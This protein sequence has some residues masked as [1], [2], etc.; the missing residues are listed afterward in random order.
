MP[1]GHGRKG[2]LMERRT[3]TIWGIVVAIWIGMS[4]GVQAQGVPVEVTKISVIGNDRAE[5][6]LILRLSGLTEGMRMTPE[7]VANAI[8]SLYAL[9]LFS[10]VRV[11]TEE[12]PEGG[13][14]MEI[15]VEELPSLRTLAFEGNRKIKKEELSDEVGFLEGQVVGPKEIRDAE[16]DIL[17]M[18]EEEGYHLA[19]VRGEVSDLDE[20]GGAEISFH[21]EEGQ[22]VRV[23]RIRIFDNDAIESSDLLKEMETKEDRWWR[24]GDFDEDVYREDQ[25]K[26]LARYRREG[27][28]DAEVVRDSLY[29]SASKKDLFIDITIHEGTQYRFG[30]ISWE[31]NDLVS[32]QALSKK[33]EIQ[34][35]EPFNEENLTL[36]RY[37]IETEYQERGYLA[38]RAIPR[39]MPAED[40]TVDLHFQIAEGTPS[41]VR[42][43]NIEGNTRTKERVIRREISIKP[44]QVFKRSALD[45]SRRD[46][47]LLN[48][49]S[50]VDV[51][52]SPPDEDGAIDLTFRVAERSTGMASMGAGYSGR[53]KLVG[54][55]GLSIPNLFGNGQQIDF[56]WDFG[57]RR[58]TFYL[59]FSEP[60]LFGTP[61]SGSV[62]MYRTT[63]S[64]LD[65]YDYRRQGGSVSMGKRLSWPDTYSRASVQYRLEEV[66]Y[67]NFDD[68]YEGSV[69]DEPSW[70]TS[71]I[72]GRYVRDT[73]NMPQFPTK[74][75]LLSYRSEVASTFFAGN[76]NFHKHQMDANLYVPTFWKFVLSLTA[77]TGV[78]KPFGDSK[79]VPTIEKFTPGGV[80]F[81]GMI[82]GYNDQSVGPRGTNNTLMGGRSILVLNLEYRFPLTEQQ[83]YGLLFADA[84]NAWAWMSDMRLSDLRYSAGV[85]FRLVAPMLGTIGFDF[86]YGFD[87]RLVDGAPPQWKIHFQ[88][89]PQFIY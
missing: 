2:D 88:F 76:A 58:E 46:V 65:Y 67:F 55:I 49:F 22:K 64:Y 52:P 37:N 87:R 79:D 42:R 32:D 8:Q 33:I 29:Y 80:D 17:R 13:V 26:I 54:T 69:R 63:R 7:S 81:D 82:R 20:K 25:A 27:Y 3:H 12:D 57:S 31:G 1:R 71:S 16:R 84:G 23:K 35:G 75:T 66:K 30:K 6:S 21:I 14:R 83:L 39:M 44:G 86:A 73:R 68:A 53:D 43:V 62:S 5:T 77:R 24:S 50:N 38:A 18:Y 85:G 15:A 4:G 60:W 9:G 19:K 51:E 36:T 41:K 78:I 89:G 45:R 48:F 40:E 10:D 56:N 74:G 72:T 59:S 34:E 61:T 11:Y 47:Y 28:R 70:T